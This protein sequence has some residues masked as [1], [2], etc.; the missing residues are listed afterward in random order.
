MATTG[1]APSRVMASPRAA[2]LADSSKSLGTATC[3][4]S[5]KLFLEN[6]DM[7]GGSWPKEPASDE[8]VKN[9]DRPRIYKGQD[10]I[11]PIQS[12]SIYNITC[13]RKLHIISKS[14]L[15]LTGTLELPSKRKS[16]GR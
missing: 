8:S 13:N 7:K 16:L 3:K 4:R 9:S 2:R 15:F 14:Q 6:Y 11:T 5:K 1:G 10:D 12:S